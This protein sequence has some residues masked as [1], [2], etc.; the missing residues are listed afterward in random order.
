VE[1]P[2]LAIENS[3]GEISNMASGVHKMLDWT[4]DCMFVKQAD[5]DL[6]RKVLHRESVMDTVQKEVI[7]FL[8]HIL[9]AETPAKTALDARQQLRIAD[10]YESVSD[11]IS[12][13]L[14]AKLSLEENDIEL[15]EKQQAGLAELHD[16]V[17][18]YVHMITDGFENP[19]AH[20]LAR[21]SSESDSITHMVKSMR[22]A[23]LES[24]SSNRI[25]PLLS[26]SYFTILN[27]YRKVKD[28][29]LNIAESLG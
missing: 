20:N 10:E 12:T 2:V 14:K 3:R 17:A 19:L 29:A 11:Y 24:L 6:V 27:S 15:T 13:I 4:R 18:V 7:D 25:D 1:S 23:H 22:S 5:K 8:T 16:K 28:H 9:S 26:M 21:A